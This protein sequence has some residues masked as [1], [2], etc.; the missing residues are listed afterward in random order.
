MMKRPEARESENTLTLQSSRTHTS[1]REPVA[2][3]F[4]VVGWGPLLL[5]S[6]LV[7]DL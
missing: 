7:W 6:R 4:G 5:K 2:H 3:G 1:L